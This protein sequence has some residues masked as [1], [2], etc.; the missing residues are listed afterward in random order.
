MPGE[1]VCSPKLRKYFDKLDNRTKIAYK[2][3]NQ[4]RAQGYDPEDKVDI[5]LA[6]S[7]G[8]RVEGNR[9]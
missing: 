1:I 9:R 5:L 3:A 7:V 4:A 6:E 2:L 8:K